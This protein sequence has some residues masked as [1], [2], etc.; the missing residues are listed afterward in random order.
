MDYLKFLD[1]Q[2]ITL[3]E[4]LSMRDKRAAIQKQMLSLPTFEKGCLICFTL[5]ISG[6]IKTFSLAEKGFYEG[7]R[8]IK[9][10][11][12]SEK[13]Q[14]IIINNQKAGYEFFCLTEADA[15]SVKRKMIQLEMMHPL[16]RLFDIDVLDENG[17]KIRRQDLDSPERRCLL[18]GQD[19]HS[20]ARGKKHPVSQLQEET[21]RILFQFDRDT[22]A[23][24]ISERVVWALLTEVATTPKPGLVDR[25]DNGAHVDMD[26][27][28][29]INSSVALKKWFRRIVV[30]NYEHADDTLDSLFEQTRFL[31]KQAEKE[32]FNVTKGV[33]THKGAIF[34]FA[35]LSAAC[36]I[37]K[38]KEK[39][40][41][42]ECVTELA[43]KMACFSLEDLNNS[44]KKQS[45]TNGLR[46]Y[47]K[48]QCKGVRGEAA[49][50]FPS[51]M[52]VGLPTLREALQSGD[53]WNRACVRVLLALLDKTEDTNLLARGGT[54][55]ADWVKNEIKNYNKWEQTPDEFAFSMNEKMIEKNLSPGGCADLLA[56]TLFLYA[57]SSEKEVNI[58]IQ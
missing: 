3:A 28:T 31:G 42:A 51:V 55:G 56:I 30:W 6:S 57:I 35:V 52:Q 24:D 17:M 38:A 44:N 34:S 19:G 33:N 14:K 21:V 12:N 25:W 10:N 5:N 22:T 40:L 36:G 20:C 46:L 18:C 43:G 37:L 27:Y 11:L 7:I 54:D 58:W 29:F 4:V 23:N 47:E 41:T 53:D 8:V 2:P 32:M 49:G 39:T 9:Q 1:G 15:R 26:F 16:G 48:Y 50:G 13:I 45:M